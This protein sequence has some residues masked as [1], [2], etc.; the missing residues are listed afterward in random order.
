MGADLKAWT[1]QIRIVA[2]VVLLLCG[3]A[4]RAGAADADA[5]WTALA[6]GEPKVLL[7]R[8]AEA[9]G[10]GDPP[11]FRLGDCATQRNLSEKGRAQAGSIGDALRRRGVPVA[12]V[13]TSQWC[14]CRDTA[15]LLDVGPVEDAPALNS[16]FDE[17]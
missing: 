2:A 13:L 17:R 1:A 15:R 10:V 8:H 11:G 7:I 4:T 9:P 14:R 5:A 12:K 16:F 3:A 6:S